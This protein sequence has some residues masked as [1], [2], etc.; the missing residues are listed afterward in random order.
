MIVTAMILAIQR[1]RKMSQGEGKAGK[2]AQWTIGYYIATTIIAVAHSTLLVALVWSKLMKR[3]SDDQLSVDPKDE[4]NFKEREDVEIHDVVVDMFYSF[5]PQNIVN[6][7]AT[8]SLLAVVVV[9]C[10]LGYVLKPG[11]ALMR[12]VEEVEVIVMRIITILIYMAPVG[13]FFLILPN[14]FRLDI[15]EIGMNLGILIAGTLTGMVIHI[16]ILIPLIYFIIVR[17]NPYSM[18]LKCSPAW[19]TA[20][21]T[22]SSAATLP[23]TIRCVLERG[24]PKSIAHFTCPLG[25]MLVS[26]VQPCIQ[27]IK[28]F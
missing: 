24:I 16:F 2:L 25:C 22:A 23:V 11:G 13:V 5:V 3:V 14:L 10:V 4:E 1:L 19:I 17:T 26:L 9:S 7:L 6:A 8:D 21:G 12:A 20:W 27:Y 15:G 28:S 18:W